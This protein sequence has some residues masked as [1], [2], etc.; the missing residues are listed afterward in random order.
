[1]V[2]LKADWEV[3]AM[4]SSGRRLAEVGARLREQIV[5]GAGIVMLDEKTVVASIGYHFYFAIGDDIL[6][7]TR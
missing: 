2:H 1:M 4:R 6:V 7:K 3:A 5:L